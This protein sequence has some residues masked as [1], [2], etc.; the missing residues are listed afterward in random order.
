MKK[1]SLLLT[2]ILSLGTVST[3]EA[4]ET[5][6]DLNFKTSNS[7]LQLRDG[8]WAW[9]WHAEFYTFIDKD[10]GIEYGVIYQDR[11]GENL[12]WHQLNWISPKLELAD[13]KVRIWG[14]SKLNYIPGSSVG[15]KGY[16]FHQRG[17]LQL[18]IK[19]GLRLTTFVEPRWQDGD[20]GFGYLGS[21]SRITL[22]K[23]FGKTTLHVGMTTY[24]NPVDKFNAET[25]Y[26]IMYTFK[27]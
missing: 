4:R 14:T 17:W 23:D 7:L 25:Q 12:T 24:G 5:E 13:G 9:N 16:G 20:D 19:P 1:I 11:D 18:M 22:D 15:P 21:K 6:R 8:I 27:F 26:V 10:K 3:L 2:L